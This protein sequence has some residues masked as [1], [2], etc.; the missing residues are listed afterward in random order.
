MLDI[1]SNSAQKH[2]LPVALVAL[3]EEVGYVDAQLV[4]DPQEMAQLHLCTAFHALKRRPVDF[5]LGGESLLGHVLVQPPDPD[6]VADGLA[7]IDDPS[8]LLVGHPSNALPIMITC[9]Q[10]FC[11]I[12]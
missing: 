1:I 9:Q 6:T 11:G 7:G 2:Y 4:C 5:R 3:V 10:H 8:G 12:N